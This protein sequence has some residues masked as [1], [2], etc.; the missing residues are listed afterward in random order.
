MPI[1]VQ[2][3]G[4]RWEDAAALAQHIQFFQ[5][6]YDVIVNR[7]VAARGDKVVLGSKPSSCRFC[8]RTKP[9]ATF[10]KE[11]H[12]VP[13]LAGAR[14]LVSLYECDECNR[15]FSAFEDDLAKMT[16]LERIAG[17]V[18]GKEGVPSAKTIKKKSRID[19]GATGFNIQENPEDP[20]AKI[21]R[22][23]RTL[24]I[25]IAPQRFRPL[26]AYKALVKVALTLMPEENLATVP[27]ALRWLLAADLTTD[28]VDDG[29]H[30]TCIR[31]W[32]PGP[33][34][35]PYTRVM[36]LRR[37]T[38]SILGPAY[39]FVLAFGNL[40]F[41]IVVPSPQQ[42]KQLI[43]QTITLRTVP[44]FPFLDPDRV[45]G[46]TRYWRQELSSTVPVQ[47]AATVTFRFDRVTELPRPPIKIK[48]TASPI[49]R[50]HTQRQ[51]L[52]GLGLN[53]IGRIA[54]VPDTEPIR[55]MIAKV[56][57]LVKVIEGS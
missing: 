53:R 3:A 50:H 49:R 8:N 5:N 55:G 25:T 1:E 42:D 38:L 16:L 43:G 40:S 33:A 17:Q 47:G 21:N 27:E 48:Q 7:V 35:I 52:I 26:G 39:I 46:P 56:G 12:A 57:H 29:T 11:A 20:I 54:E 31:S 30:Y 19:M 15:R 2:I 22:E 37:K 6:G 23:Q 24:T 45:R 10:R 28:R 34:P 36:L 9:H 4:I 13:E 44:I 18:L 32:T 41:Q 14:T 51:T